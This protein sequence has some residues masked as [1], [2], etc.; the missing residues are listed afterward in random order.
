[1]NRHAV[2]VAYH[3]DA[4]ALAVLLQTLL[5]AGCRVVVVDNTPG[6]GARAAPLPAGCELIALGDNRGIA[7]AQNVGIRH[8]RQQGADAILF[9]DQDSTIDA[10][11]VPALLAGL[12]RGQPG[13]VGPVCID[14]ARGF[15]YPAYRLSRWGY[16]LKVLSAARSLPYPVDLII[17]SGSAATS[18]TF[19]IVGL[20]DED[21][22][23]D[24]VDLEWCLRCRALGVT[25]T[26][27]P[28]VT[29]RHSIGEV[30]VP[31]GPLTTFVHS[32]ARRYYRMRNAFLMLRK[33]HVPALFGLKSVVSALAHALLQLPMVEN[34]REHLAVCWAGLL[35]GLR[36]VRGRRA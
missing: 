21:F 28:R 6:P 11:F 33:P 22:F 25:I 30:S 13:V 1:M 4:A 36:G 15:E 9:F 12:V 3:P 16:P 34:R 17:S 29:L 10:A 8:A 24:G 27:D 7:E 19:D 23:I 14:A 35:D 20:L 26:V 5:A 2:I 18:V 31:V 32:P